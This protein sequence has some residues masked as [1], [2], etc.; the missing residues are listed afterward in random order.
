[1]RRSLPPFAL[2]LLLVLLAWALAPR[3]IARA[4]PEPAPAPAPAP[5]A[6]QEVPKGAVRFDDGDSITVRW[7]D[8]VEVVRIL[9]ID[10]PEVQHLEHDLPFAQSF[11]DQAAGF[12]RG[13]V[14]V[15]DRIEILRAKDEDRYGR[16]LA[17]L[18][19]DGKNYSAL[20]VEAGLAVATVDHYGDNG[21]PEQAAE[22]ARAAEGAGP[23]PFEPPHVYRARM[24]RVAAWM[25]KQGTYPRAGV[26]KEAR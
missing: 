19:L 5:P 12:L 9:G 18:L 4:E 11:G 6:R 23:V 8:G 15:C 26:D 14:A 10:T 25:R 22:V 21:L 24:R 2:L 3:T 20:V 13:C 17:Y 7:E 16:T 1:M